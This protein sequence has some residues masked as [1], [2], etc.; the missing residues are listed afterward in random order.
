M[1][2]DEDMAVIVEYSRKRW[3]FWAHKEDEIRSQLHSDEAR[4]EL[5][6]RLMREVHRYDD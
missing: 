4:A 3:E 6:R 5:N 1:I 2:S